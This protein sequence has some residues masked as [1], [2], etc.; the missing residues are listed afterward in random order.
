MQFSSIYLMR[1]SRELTLPLDS[2]SVEMVFRGIYHFTQA[3]NQGKT[4]DIVAYFTAPE[5]RDLGIV[6]SLR[7]KRAKPP[8]NLS[9]SSS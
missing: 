9:P 3:S 6:K 5:N 4:T 2:I 8:L 7:P 1:L